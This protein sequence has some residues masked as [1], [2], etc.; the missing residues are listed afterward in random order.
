MIK[1]RLRDDIDK[2][3]IFDDHIDSVNEY[4]AV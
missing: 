4:S 1:N 2:N 3:Y